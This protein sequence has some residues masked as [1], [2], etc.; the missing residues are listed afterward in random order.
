MRLKLIC[1]VLVGLLVVAAGCGGSKKKS[2]ETT[3][4]TAATTSESTTSA[5]TSESTT[6]ATGGLNLTSDDCAKLAAASATVGKAFSGTVSEGTDEDIAR[7]QQLAEVAPDEIKGDFEV[8]AEAASEYSKLGLKA[9]VTPTPEQLQKLS[10]LDVV[11]I[12]QAT[13]NISAWAQKN[14]GVTK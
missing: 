3:A 14:C 10:S 12:T 1:V 9:G 5:T 8:L 11:K 4:S 6:S 7:L 13:S 2:T